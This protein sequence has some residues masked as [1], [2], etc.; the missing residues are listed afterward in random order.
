MPV[1]LFGIKQTT[2]VLWRPANTAPPPKLVI[3]EFTPGN[4]PSLSHRKEFALTPLPGKTD[5]GGVDASACGLADG[6]VYHYWFEV[7]DS[8]PARNGSR[9]LCTDPTAFT[10]D[11]RLQ[12]PLLPPP[13]K[14]ED[15]DP[16]SVVKFKG[17]KLVPCDAAGE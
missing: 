8:S 2:F 6:K 7:T 14:D 15:Q 12:A 11:W 5:L 1:N 13:Y 17:G 9:I 10:V 3:G 4:P 16:A